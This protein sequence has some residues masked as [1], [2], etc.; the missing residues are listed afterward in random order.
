MSSQRRSFFGACLAHLLH[1][2]YTDQLYVLLP[3]WR[4]EFGLSYAS[5]AVVRLL[6]YGT[7]GALQV[8]GDR[9]IS[10]LAPRFSLTLATLV[11]ACGYF[12]MA[13]PLGLVGLCAGLLVAG[14]GSSI[15]HPRASLLV[16]SAYPKRS[17]E[18]LG[19]Y[20]F[21]GDLGKTIFPVSAAALLPL[22]PWRSVTAI[23]GGVGICAA[24]ALWNLIP[25]GG[26]S[27]PDAG[28]Q[29]AARGGRG[30]WLLATIGVLDTAPRMGYL[31][32]LPFLISAKG[33]SEA[34]LGLGL[35]LVF[36][37]G[38]LGKALCGWLGRKIG[39]VASVIATEAATALLII[40]TLFVPLSAVLMLLPVLGLALN[41]TSS[42]LYG[43]VPEL[44]PRGDVGRAFA[45]FYTGTICSGAL[46]PVLFGV[47]ADH[48]SRNVGTLAAAFTAASIVPLILILRPALRHPVLPARATPGD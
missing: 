14:L 31:L 48:A 46:A 6:Y 4:A 39:V 30:F 18:P 15:Q 44:A 33:G 23:M 9:W 24:L 32:F 45:I 11:A 10:R 40:V 17:R 27:L 37:G 47:I 36:I 42:V 8:P 38:A 12:T 34:T 41:G 5:L 28:E 29:G 13:L 1:D 2:G 35:A 16:T 21:A 25:A 7:M 43:T 3:L 19:V 22:L 26:A 20:N